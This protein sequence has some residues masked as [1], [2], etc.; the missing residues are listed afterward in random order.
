M[1][2]LVDTSV[3][4]LALRRSSDNHQHTHVMHLSH[5]IQ[6]TLVQIIGPIRQELLSGLASVEQF[7]K[8]RDYLSAF[9]DMRLTQE[10]YEFA[11]ELYNT[12]RKKGIQG[13]N[14]DFLICSTAIHHQLHILTI[15]KDF[16]HFSKYIPISLYLI[17][18]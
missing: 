12:C 5:L 7:N 16:Y 9:E 11:A 6:N 13:S 1:G 15:D 14:T 17:P 2:V 10:D 3:W 18:V 8:L 4:S